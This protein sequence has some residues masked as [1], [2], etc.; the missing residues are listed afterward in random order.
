MSQGG[1]CGVAWG[2]QHVPRRHPIIGRQLIQ[3]F[4]IRHD[5]SKIMKWIHTILLPASVRQ[6]IPIYP[7]VAAQQHVQDAV[8]ICFTIKS[9]Y[10]ALPSLLDW[11]LSIESKKLPAGLTIPAGL[12]IQ[13]E[14]CSNVSWQP[15]HPSGDRLASFNPAASPLAALGNDTCPRQSSGVPAGTPLLLIFLCSMSSQELCLPL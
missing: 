9:I 3:R 14:P 4:M 15:L 11:N 12:L 1:P 7:L 6:A 13:L 10:S 2:H 8:S 5:T